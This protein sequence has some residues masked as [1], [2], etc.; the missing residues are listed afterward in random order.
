MNG[1]GAKVVIETGDR[2]S[3]ISD[4]VL[5]SGNL[6]IGPNSLI[7]NGTIY[8]N[9][10]GLVG[11]TSSYLTLAGSALDQSLNAITLRSFTMNRSSTCTL[12]GAMTTTDLN[13]SAG[14]LALAN[15]SLTVNSRIIRTNGTLSGNVNS[16]L[17]LNLAYDLSNLPA[18]TLGIIIAPGTQISGFGVKH[19]PD[20]QTLPG[21][22]SI[23]RSWSLAG[24]FDTA[25]GLT[26]TWDSSADN[27]LGFSSTN[28]AQVYR[29]AGSG[30]QQYGNPVDVSGS[31]PRSISVSAE[32]FSDWTV[33][34][35][36]ETLPVSLS[37]FSVVV[38]CQNYVMLTW[39]TQSESN[40]VGFRLLR[41][42]TPS[43]AEALDL[44]VL[45]PATNTSTLQ[46]YSHTDREVS[47]PTILN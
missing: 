39:V 25:V 42:E 18:L 3:T 17:T 46:C 10:G 24:S 16:S 12:L 6:N 40:L 5:N 43:L 13:L 26:F 31:D 36:D 14:T 22:N 34:L 7:L 15:S 37:S 11:T 19:S 28:L 29:N 4:L 44:N 20:A 47:A 9:G 41:S 21:G 38:S 45:I 30:W 1:S 8:Y 23:Q 32:A 27:G 35:S 33:D 2:I